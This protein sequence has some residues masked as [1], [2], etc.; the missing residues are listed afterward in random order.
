MAEL[1]LSA[2]VTVSRDQTA[3]L[4]EGV[5]NEF[6]CTGT[7]QGHSRYVMSVTTMPAS[8]QYPNGLIITGS[9]DQTINVYDPHVEAGPLQQLT[10][11]TDAVCC[12]AVTADGALLSSS[13][14]GTAKVWQEF[15][16]SATL[17]GHERSVL[18]VTAHPTQ[19]IAVT[20][21]ADLKIKLWTFA[22]TCT[23]TF[24]G[25]TDVI[26]AIVSLDEQQFATC[27][28]DGTIRVW[29]YELGPT[30]IISPAHDSFVYSLT[31]IPGST[32]LD[33]ASSSEDGTVKIW[34]G[35]VNVQTIIMPCTSVW[36]LACR[37][38][39]DLLVGGD[40]GVARIFTLD[41]TRRAPD[42]LAVQ[43][44]Q[45]VQAAVS[46]RAGTMLG[47]VDKRT[48]PGIERLQRAGAR[49]GETVMINQ[50]GQV[51]AYSW[52]A[53]E[54]TWVS[55]GVVTDAV[56]DYVTFQIELDNKK[57]ALRHKKGDNPYLSAQQ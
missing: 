38:N 2:V 20:C 4:W 9:L 44:D 37:A 3:R 55:Q 33:L 5:G 12:L 1:S 45:L 18:G 50:G 22:G 46:A 6:Q 35:G 15:E 51:T 11:H 34:R 17:K 31:A 41:P 19:Q 47:D 25:H 7:F 53:L 49:D 27:A 21:S 36:H 42:V 29:S 40:D 32:G 54:N 48:L 26:R 57:M 16:C 52:S 56:D 23:K 30:M 10:G 39:G 8:A 13:W 28:N 24:E 43:F 14:D